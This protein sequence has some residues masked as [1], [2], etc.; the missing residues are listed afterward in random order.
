MYPRFSNRS[1]WRPTVPVR[2]L[3]NCD[4][5]WRSAIRVA[6]VAG[7]LCGA[8]RLASAQVTLEVLDVNPQSPAT[9]GKYQNF[10]LRIGYTC[11]QPIFLRAQPFL[12]GVRVPAMNGG[13]PVYNAGSGEAFFWLAATSPGKVDEVLITAAGKDGKNLAQITYPVSLSWTP[14]LDENPPPAPEWVKRMKEA[15]Q[16]KIAAQATTFNQDAA[17]WAMIGIGSLIMLCVPVYF[18]A[19]VVL[20]WRLKDKWRK[21]AA[22]PLVPMAFVLLYT[23]WAYHDGS[24]LYPI[25][26]IFA[27]PAAL[28]YLAVVTLWWRLSGRTA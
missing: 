23:V 26:L 3:L 1:L 15:Q 22:A 18:V 5:A 7:I 28:F 17:G 25:V 2:E 27:S 4:F 19:Q 20:L 8:A 9:L 21:A 14:E 10:S 24:N 13:S 6:F 12:E 11:D 16:S